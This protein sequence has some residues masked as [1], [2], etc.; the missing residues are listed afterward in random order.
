MGV[1]WEHTPPWNRWGES[2]P[3]GPVTLND[4]ATID[5]FPENVAVAEM[6]GAELLRGKPSASTVVPD[7]RDPAYD[8]KA[9]LATGEIDPAKTYRV[10]MGFCG[11]PSYGAEPERMP[12]VFPFDTPQYF[13]AVKSNRVPLK[14][15]RQLSVQ[16]VEATAKY[17]RRHQRISP[18]PGLFSI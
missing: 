4:L 8:G 10:A 17:I 2:L 18:L 16:V 6:T 5:M 12:K 14:N 9:H 11:M 15:F 3:A 1:I 13:L 7:R